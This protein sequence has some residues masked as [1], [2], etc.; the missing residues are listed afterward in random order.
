VFLYSVWRTLVFELGYECSDCNAHMD[1]SIEL[2]KLS[3]LTFGIVGQV[4]Q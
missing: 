4:P 3:D 1:T 2:S